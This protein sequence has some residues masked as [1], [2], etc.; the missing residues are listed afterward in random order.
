MI[1]NFLVCVCL[2][3]AC[4]ICFAGN[5]QYPSEGG[6]MENPLMYCVLTILFLGY[7]KLYQYLLEK[8]QDKK[9][10]INNIYGIVLITILVVPILLATIKIFIK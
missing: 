7:A 1:K 9:V 3:R 5:G 4:N 8:F 6:P 2:L 10:L